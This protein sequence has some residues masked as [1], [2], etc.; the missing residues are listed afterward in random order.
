M[1]LFTLASGRRRPQRPA[2]PLRHLGAG[3]VLACLSAWM[4]MAQADTLLP[5]DPALRQQILKYTTPARYAMP[6]LSPDGRHLAVLS[7]V[8]GRQNLVVIDLAQR[9]AAAD[10]PYLIK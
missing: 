7:P 9:K 8:G 4:P 1:P 3:L 2:S 5:S 6:T 10:F